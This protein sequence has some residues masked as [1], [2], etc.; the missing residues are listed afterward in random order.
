[1]V[2]NTRDLVVGTFELFSSQ[3]ALR[4]N[5]TM[6]AL[7]F[8][9]VLI[10]TMAVVAGVLGMN[11]DAPFFDAGAKGFWWA[12]AGMGAIVVVAVVLGRRRR[13]L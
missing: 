8:Y 6:R 13:W 5:E 9:T 2:Q 11:F 10:G 12:L 3:T 4:T 1:M 7:T